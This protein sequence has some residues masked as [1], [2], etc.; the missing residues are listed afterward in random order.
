MNVPDG[1]SFNQETKNLKTGE[2]MTIRRYFFIA[3]LLISLAIVLV[4]TIF[5]GGCSRKEETIDISAVKKENTVDPEANL[6]SIKIEGYA[7]P[8]A[9]IS[10]YELQK[11]IPDPSI[12]V[13][14]TRSRNVRKHKLT[15]LAGHI[16]GAK[17]VMYG[18]LLNQTY[19]G[20]IAG[21]AQFQDVLGKRGVSNNSCIVLYGND[22]LEAHLYWAIKMYGYAN[23]KILDGGLDKW[24]EAGFDITNVVV[25]P[26]PKTFNFDLTNSKAELMLATMQEVEGAINNPNYVIV[27]AR[28]NKE[29]EKGHIPGSV[30]IPCTELFIKDMTFKP[31]PHLKQLFEENEITPDKKV[32]V[33][34]KQGVRSSLI[35]FALSELLEYPNVK[36]YDGSLNEWLMFERPVNT[37]TE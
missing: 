11:K 34:S 35:W 26:A 9:L 33:Y 36:N 27:D 32:I 12:D 20:R 19:S 13:L 31:A 29:Y 2:R 10:V 30:N 16:P 28:D 37:D 22:G 14:D 21:P 15:Y 8:E 25:K 17:A 1:M 18:N 6:A 23:V 4:G 5:L 24:Q 7:R 3:S